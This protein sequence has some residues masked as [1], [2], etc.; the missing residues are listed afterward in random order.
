MFNDIGKKIKGLAK[1]LSW[2]GIIA[3]C[4]TGIVFLALASHDGLFALYGLLTAAVG[5]LLSWVGGFFVYGFGELIDKEDKIYKL[6]GGEDA[7]P[8][9][10]PQTSANQTASAGQTSLAK[11]AQSHWFCPNCGRSYE[12][13]VKKCVDCGTDRPAK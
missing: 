5:S 2:V 3:S 4:I 11:E 1:I 9:E 7:V 13:W 6:L 12:F 8:A 10:A